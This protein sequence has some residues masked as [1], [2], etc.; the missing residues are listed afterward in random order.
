VKR[1]LDA[2]GASWGGALAETP[3]RLDLTMRLVRD[4]DQQANARV[5]WID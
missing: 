1:R 3:R 4:H 5:N 2:P